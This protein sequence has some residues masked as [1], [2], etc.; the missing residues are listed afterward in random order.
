ME[1][2]IMCKSR[3]LANSLSMSAL[4]A[5]LFASPLLLSSRIATADESLLPTMTI[6]Y[7]ELNMQSSAGVQA[8]YARL[9]SAAKTVCATHDGRSLQQQ[10]AF[11][12]CVAE[13]LERA[14]REVHSDAVLALHVEHSA[15]PR[16][17]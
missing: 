6:H 1:Q 12:A 13:T 3:F 7:S 11:R 14:V 4:S 17:G 8:L 15:T 5:M 9:R 10:F 16:R 2:A